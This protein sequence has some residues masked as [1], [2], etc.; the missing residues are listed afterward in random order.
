VSILVR[1]HPGFPSV[2][3]PKKPYSVY[4]LNLDPAQQ[5]AA[6]VG[7]RQTYLFWDVTFQRGPSIQRGLAEWEQFA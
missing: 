5:G 1:Q 4:D 2:W 7:Y 3:S 6:T